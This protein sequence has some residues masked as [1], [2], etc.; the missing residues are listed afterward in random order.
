MSKMRLKVCGGVSLC[1][2]YG[3]ENDVYVITGW[4]KVKIMF[5]KMFQ[6][7]IQGIEAPIKILGIYI[8]VYGLYISAYF[9]WVKMV[10]RQPR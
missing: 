10:E 2:W 6:K 4:S 3:S 5:L 1:V 7:N 8:F 9:L